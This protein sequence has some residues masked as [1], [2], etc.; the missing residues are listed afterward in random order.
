[1]Q[2][3][4]VAK[5]QKDL[6]GIKL[7]PHQ[8]KELREQLANWEDPDG[9]GAAAIT[10]GLLRKP[11]RKAVFKL[12]KALL[13][14]EHEFPL[15]EAI[16]SF[17]QWREPSVV[18][19]LEALIDVAKRRKD[20]ILLS[21]ILKSLYRI[22]TKRARQLLAPYAEYDIQ[23]VRLA[24]IGRWDE[25]NLSTTRCEADVWPGRKQ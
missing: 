1:M 5:E 23:L 18:P 10:A 25:I 21:R 20:Y 4:R 17:G 19:I 13:T 9:Q 2:E 12:L 8:L 7:S 16:D 14:S 11:Q 24:A 3:I 6:V 22:G 15:K